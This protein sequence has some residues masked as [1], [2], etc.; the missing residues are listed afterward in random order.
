MQTFAIGTAT[1]AVLKLNLTFFE[2]KTG[3]VEE[4]VAFH[5]VSAYFWTLTKQTVRNCFLATLA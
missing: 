1:Q 3:V 4:E 5:T 2:L